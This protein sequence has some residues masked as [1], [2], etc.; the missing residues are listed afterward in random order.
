MSSLP[1]ASQADSQNGGGGTRVL[2]GFSKS[3]TLELVRESPQSL[4]VE[5]TASA[6]NTTPLYLSAFVNIS[7]CART[8]HAYG[9]SWLLNMQTLAQPCHRVSRGFHQITTITKPFT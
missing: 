2:K 1:L 9:E 7:R 8:Y 3:S 4:N 5:D 6:N